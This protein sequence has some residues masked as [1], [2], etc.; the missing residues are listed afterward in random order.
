M[1]HLSL[2]LLLP[3]QQLL[4]LFLLSTAIV[5]VVAAAETLL[6]LLLLHYTWCNCYYYFLFLFLL[7]FLLLC[8]VTAV[9]ECIFVKPSPLPDGPP[10]P[11]A[12]VCSGV[13]Q[14]QTVVQEPKL[15]RGRGMRRLHVGRRRRRRRHSCY[16]SFPPTHILISTYTPLLAFWGDAHKLFTFL[17][18]PSSAAAIQIRHT[19]LPFPLFAFRYLRKVIFIFFSA[20]P[21]LW[22]YACCVVSLQGVLLVRNKRKRSRYKGKVKNLARKQW[23]DRGGRRL[24]EF[25][26]RRRRRRHHGRRPMIRSRSMMELCALVSCASWWQLD[27]FIL[28]LSLHIEL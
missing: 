10:A 24:W 25:S 1:Y 3:S 18:A 22:E 13:V 5:V 12:K 14:I 27:Q 9:R 23:G 17:S 16:A 20:F 4:L 26:G 15:R 11:R 21:L 2:L 28:F 6:L 19:T 8:S 7:L